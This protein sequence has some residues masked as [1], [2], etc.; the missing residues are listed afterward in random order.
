MKIG[1]ISE[2]YGGTTPP[3]GYGGISGTVYDLVCE[4]IRH[5]HEVTLFATPGSF[6]AGAR[7]VI[8]DAYD[9]QGCNPGPLPPYAVEALKYVNDIEVWMDGSHHKWFARECKARYPW[10]NVVCPAWNPNREDLPQNSVVQSPAMIQGI[11]GGMPDTTPWFWG[12]IPL[13]E[14]EPCY[15]VGRRA[16]SVM[17]LT[18]YKGIDILVRSARKHKFPLDLYGH[19]PS[20]VWYSQAVEPYVDGELVVY[21]GPCGLDR[22]QHFANASMSFLIATWWE[23]GSRAVL[24]SLACGCPTVLTKAGSLR[25]YIEDGVSGAYVEDNERSVYEGYL[26]VL[27]GGSEMRRQARKVAEEKFS[28]VAYA[29]NWERMFERAMRGERW[30]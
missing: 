8:C 2:M 24:E 6:V 10:V 20:D 5:G 29:S 4:F 27:E 1:V 28:L 9:R 22:K 23:P 30:E 14:Y 21:H 11:G 12:G 25:Y 3:T 15:E 26:R 13:D 16:V 17:V 18:P 19:T 7:M